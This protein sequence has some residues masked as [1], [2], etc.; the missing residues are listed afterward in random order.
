MLQQPGSVK[1]PGPALRETRNKAH[2]LQRPLATYHERARV[3]VRLTHVLLSP[4]GEFPFHNRAGSTRRHK[5]GRQVIHQVSH[6]PS[7][8]GRRQHPLREH[9]IHSKLKTP[10]APR[11]R[12]KRAASSTNL[13]TNRLHAMSRFDV[14]VE[15]EP[16]EEEL[17]LKLVEQAVRPL[18]SAGHDVAVVKERGINPKVPARRRQRL[19]V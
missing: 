18:R 5:A 11:P 12:R 4:S 13:S 16:R 3:L 2:A 14:A 19:P 7:R 17:L 8:V 15:Q 1:A 9:L 10:S 6:Q